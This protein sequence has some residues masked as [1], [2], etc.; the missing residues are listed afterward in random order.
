[1]VEKYQ[2]L[3]CKIGWFFPEG[4]T[5]AREIFNLSDKDSQAT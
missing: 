2:L 4:K 1:V 5:R 3:T